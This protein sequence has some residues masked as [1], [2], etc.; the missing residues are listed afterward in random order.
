MAKVTRTKTSGTRR[1]TKS[2]DNIGTI[3]PVA[4][5]PLTNLKMA[6]FGDSG[7][8]KTT[9]ACSFPKKLL[10]LGCEEGTISIDPK[11]VKGTDFVAIKSTKQMRALIRRQKEQCIYK[12]LVVDTLTKYQEL[13]LGEV[14]GIEDISANMGFGTVDRDQ[15]GEATRVMKAT[16]NML[17]ALTNCNVLFLSQQKSIEPEDTGGGISPT[18]TSAL[19]PSVATHLKPECHYHV[20]TY[21]DEIKS[22]RSV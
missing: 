16:I 1:V 6:V 22:Y 20:Q 5:V 9:F 2:G 8:G 17:C 3:I 11:D 4:D 15:W 12:T 7:S 14:L 10:V 18:I 19:M 21:L 13:V